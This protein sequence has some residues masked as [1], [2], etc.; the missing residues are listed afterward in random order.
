MALGT[1]GIF[2]PVKKLKIYNLYSVLMYCITSITLFSSMCRWSDERGFLHPPNPYFPQ[3]EKD[4]GKIRS[5]IL[6]LCK[7]T[8]PRQPKMYTESD[9]C[10]SKYLL[11]CPFDDFFFYQEILNI[12]TL[13]KARVVYRY[14]IFSIELANCRSKV[15]TIWSVSSV[16]VLWLTLLNLFNC[17]QFFFN[18]FDPP[19]NNKKVFCCI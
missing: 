14:W 7:F 2:V 6:I 8:V 18:A 12:G 9:L 17:K 11:H 19:Q 4:P 3:Q 5:K 10:C 15:W 13:F 1:W 16:H